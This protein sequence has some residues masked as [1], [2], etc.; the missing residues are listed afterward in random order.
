MIYLE[1]TISLWETRLD[2]SVLE[3]SAESADHRTVR[4]SY[5]TFV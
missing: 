1:H 5:H 3:L 4:G 2:G